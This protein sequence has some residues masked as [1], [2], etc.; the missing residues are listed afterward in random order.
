MSILAL[1]SIY[2]TLHNGLSQSLYLI[3]MLS[4]TREERAGSFWL[5]LMKVTISSVD[6]TSTERGHGVVFDNQ[7]RM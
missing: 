5:V 6:V 3:N 2:I 1:K 7:L 4:A